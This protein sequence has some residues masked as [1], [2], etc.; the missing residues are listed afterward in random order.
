M[1]TLKWLS[2]GVFED[3]CREAWN[4]DRTLGETYTAMR[5]V[6]ERAAEAAPT[7]RNAEYV[8]T[9]RQSTSALAER[10][11]AAEQIAGSGYV[12][13]PAA[14]PERTCA[15]CQFWA[16]LSDRDGKPANG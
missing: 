4:E 1:T 15:T 10:T 3:L 9:L 5:A 13:A 8:A 6:L 11:V 14:D 12:A 16:K 2:V 7:E